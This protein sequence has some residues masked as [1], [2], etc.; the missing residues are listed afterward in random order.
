MKKDFKLLKEG[1]VVINKKGEKTE[2]EYPYVAKTMDNYMQDI[3]DYLKKIDPELANT[4]SYPW[5][6]DPRFVQIEYDE[7]GCE[8]V[9]LDVSKMKESEVDWD[10]DYVFVKTDK[11]SPCKN[12]MIDRLQC[13]TDVE[14]PRKISELSHEELVAL[15][16][17]IVCG[18]CYIS[19]YNNS[20]FVE[21]KV[22]CDA[23]DFYL[24][25]LE[26]DGRDDT[27]ENFASC[28]EG[29]IEY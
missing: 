19:D 21:N 22:V 10:Y 11:S 2:I 23:S 13:L 15:R 1:T 9:V 27:P 24:E 8:Y 17:E 29:Y 26:E 6:C 4:E 25:L 18:S 16:G 12:W 28:V 3:W 14:L 20:F 5:D 7:I